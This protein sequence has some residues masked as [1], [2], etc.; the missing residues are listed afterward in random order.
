MREGSRRNAWFM[1]AI[2]LYALPLGPVKR[3]ERAF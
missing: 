1:A 3:E 2:L